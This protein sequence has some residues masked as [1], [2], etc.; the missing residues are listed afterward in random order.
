M[1]NIL[2]NIFSKAGL[3]ESAAGT[4]T[5]EEKI[6]LATLALFLEMAQI[7]GEFS[8]EEINRI[9]EIFTGEYGLK[10]D[11]LERLTRMA[12]QELKDSH[13]LWRFTNLL[14]RD[15]SRVEKIRIVELIWKIIY[16]DGKL[17]RYE[18]YLIHKLARL[19]NLAHS[20]LIDAK[21]KILHQDS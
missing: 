21:L 16:A 18:D 12:K 14:N 5:A 6:Y 2:Q 19:L 17:D 1:V 15:L 13:D 8:Q 20:D 10:K 7:D 4:T 3:E 9:T 11:Y